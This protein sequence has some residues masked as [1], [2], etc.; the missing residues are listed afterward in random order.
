MLK[1]GHDKFKLEIFEYCDKNTLMEKEQFYLD[2][3]NP[4]YNILK[5]AYS[6]EG[7]RHDAETLDYLKNREHKDNLSKA[8]TGRTFS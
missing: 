4:S 5:Q 2:Q 1:Y 6:L 3:L 7:F 8:I